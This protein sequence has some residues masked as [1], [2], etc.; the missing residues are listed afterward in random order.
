MQLSPKDAAPD[1][2]L[3]ILLHESRSSRGE[4]Q[5]ILPRLHELGYSTL[6]VDLSAGLEC[7][8]VKNV[9]ARK[10]SELG[11]TPQHREMFLR[12]LLSGR[13]DPDQM[14]FLGA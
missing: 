5:P 8:E 3:L 4:Y 7:R 14:D 9:T 10:A 13:V 12:K 6:N 2:P 1:V 11:R